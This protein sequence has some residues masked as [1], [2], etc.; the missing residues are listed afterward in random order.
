[1]GV[2]TYRTAEVQHTGYRDVG[3]QRAYA[4]IQEGDAYVL[5]VRT[6]AEF[7]DRRIPGAVNIPV[8]SPNELRESWMEVPMDRPVVV[9]CRTGRRSSIAAEFLAEKGYTEVY[10]VLGGINRWE[11]RGLPVTG[12]TD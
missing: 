2:A 5:D 3:P 11:S 12:S 8:E 10:N 9:Y 4:I 1:M 6:A 7:G